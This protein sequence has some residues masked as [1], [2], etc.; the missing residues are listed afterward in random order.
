MF[1]VAATCVP[2]AEF[3]G[4]TE[5]D[6]TYAVTVLFRRKSDGAQF[7]GFFLIGMLR[8]SFRGMLARILAFTMVPPGGFPLVRHFLKCEKSKR[9]E[10]GV[11][12]EPFA[13]RGRP[14]PARNAASSRWV[15]G[16][17]RRRRHVCPYLHMP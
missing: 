15:A 4:R 14:I 11:T 6:D 7:L 8:Y 2:T 16:G 9:N 17:W 10:S 12:K 3:N 1:P 13:L 5:L